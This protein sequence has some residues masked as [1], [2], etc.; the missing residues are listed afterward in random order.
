MPLGS[1]YICV[2]DKT[3]RVA[4]G[5]ANVTLAFATGLRLASYTKTMRLLLYTV[6]TVAV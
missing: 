4:P 5:F 2:G 6:L 3:A 1:V